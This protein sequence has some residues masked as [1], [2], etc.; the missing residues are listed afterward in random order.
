MIL[1][2]QN[3]ERQLNQSALAFPFEPLIISLT[4]LNGKTLPFVVSKLFSIASSLACLLV[5][6]AF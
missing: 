2:S 3:S 1:Q 6:H 5:T 4:T